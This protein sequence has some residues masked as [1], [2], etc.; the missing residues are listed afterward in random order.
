MK[1]LIL[2]NSNIFQRKIY[3]ALKK[4]KNI[5]IEVASKRKI[6]KNLKIKKKLF[7]I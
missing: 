6:N 2:G 5:E 1:V 7:L 3:F 4:F